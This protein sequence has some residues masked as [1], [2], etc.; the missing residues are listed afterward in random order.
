MLDGEDGGFAAA[1]Q[2]QLLQDVADV[3]AGGLFGDGEG[4]C[5]QFVRIAT[6]YQR[7]HF[8]FALGQLPAWR[9]AY[10]VQGPLRG[11][12]IDQRLPG[13]DQANRA[14]QFGAAQVLQEVATGSCQD[15]RDD[16]VFIGV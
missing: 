15:G 1:R 13:G 14:Q 8:A 7:Q 2:P 4:I 12:G 16:G 6:R 11:V 9:L 3:V 10:T 5:D